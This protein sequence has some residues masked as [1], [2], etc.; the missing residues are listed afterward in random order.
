MY[1]KSKALPTVK[2]VPTA[3]Q[4]V[5]AKSE[6]YDRFSSGKPSVSR[7]KISWNEPKCNGATIGKYLL[8]VFETVST[9]D[10]Q[11][12]SP[13]RAKWNNVYCNINREVVLSG[14]AL[15]VDEWKLRVRAK[16]SEGWGEFSS[17]LVINRQT[18]PSLFPLKY[19]NSESFKRSSP[20][21]TRDSSLDS[22]I[23]PLKSIVLSDY[24]MTNFGS[25]ID[26]DIYSLYESSFQKIVSKPRDI[27]T[28]EARKHTLNANIQ[29]RPTSPISP[30]AVEEGSLSEFNKALDY[31][32]ER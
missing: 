2:D 6:I 26:K 7:V 10:S 5:R 28:P 22:P 1:S 3:P 4:S 30:I 8:Q 13:P 32:I 20:S 23:T 16:N 17:V 15:D 9:I 19:Q 12:E 27:S 24:A 11:G 14:P 18:H 21:N 25:E 29:S 31:E